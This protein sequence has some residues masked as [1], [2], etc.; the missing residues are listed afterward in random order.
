MGI[1][2]KSAPFSLIHDLDT[3]QAEQ[4]NALDRAERIQMILQ[5]VR[6]PLAADASE[7]DLHEYA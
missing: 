5:M 3:A 7:T 2:G 6:Y 1:S 4:I